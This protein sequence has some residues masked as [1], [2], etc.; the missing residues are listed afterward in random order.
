MVS[1][2]DLETYIRVKEYIEE[3]D[4]TIE[5]LL[6]SFDDGLIL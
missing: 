6:R 1:L 4:V 5:D 2:K 3:N